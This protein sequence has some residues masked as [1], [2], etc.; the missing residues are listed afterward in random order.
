[1]A[2]LA[3]LAMLTALAC[4]SEPGEGKD[5]PYSDPPSGHEF[6]KV[7]LNMNDNDVRRILGDPDHSNA[8]QTG[9]AW[10][11]F[12]YGPDTSRSDWMYTGKGRIV[13]S[14]NRYSGGLK[15]IR[16]LYNPNEE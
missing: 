4:A 10:I 6:T 15:V 7:E 8:Y 5:S 9:K 11:P 2:I 12:Y 16:I 1:M 3:L 14:R 13:F